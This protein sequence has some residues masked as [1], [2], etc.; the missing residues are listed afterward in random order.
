MALFDQLKEEYISAMK[1][2]DVVKKEILSFVISQ[3]KN[4][5]I[6]AQEDLSDDD[7]IKII[8][9]E[10]KSR[11]ETLEYLNKAGNSEDASIETQ[12]IELLH[13]YLPEM[14]WEE[15]LQQIVQQKREQL[16]IEDLGKQRWLL[17]KEI[18]QEYGAQ[19]DGALLN[20]VIQSSL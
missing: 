16:G 10:I 3:I 13:A 15:Q 5:Q 20:Q 18:M 19:V 11:E 8:K 12:K 17:I 14:I 7:V 9:K 2:K 1:A 6:D 4:K